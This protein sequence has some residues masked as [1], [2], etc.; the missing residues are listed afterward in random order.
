MGDLP[1]P[2]TGGTEVEIPSF[3]AWFIGFGGGWGG[4]YTDEVVLSAPG[5]CIPSDMGVAVSISSPGRRI[6]PIVSLRSDGDLLDG[7]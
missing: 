7:S 6:S 2:V 3:R 4:E 5:D 1:S